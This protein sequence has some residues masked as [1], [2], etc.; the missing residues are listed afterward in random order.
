[1]KNKLILS[2]LSGVLLWAGWPTSFAFPL[3]FIAL[4][5]LYVL[6]DTIE[7]DD[8]TIKKGRAV[9]LYSFITFFTWNATTT[10]WIWNAS[11]GGA[12][13]AIIANALLMTIPVLINFHIWKYKK[14]WFKGLSFAALWLVF[15]YGHLR[16]DLSWVW[17]NLGNAFA[18]STFL[19][20]WYEYTG[21]LGGSAWI[22]IVNYL[23]YLGLQKKSFK[24]FIPA[25][26]SI[27][28]PIIFSIYL[29]LNINSISTNHD[30]AL[31]NAIIV[32]PN[33]DPYKEKFFT[34][35]NFIPFEDQ[36]LR[37]IKLSE[38]KMNPDTRWLIWPET[39]IQ[40]YRPF[41]EAHI[42]Q[43]PAIKR[44][45]LFLSDYPKVKII[46]G[47]DTWGKVNPKDAHITAPKYHKK[48]GY[49]KTYNSAIIITKD[50]SE[51]YHKSKLV[52]GVEVLPFPSILKPI[53]DL[54][55][56]EGSG[57]FGKSKEPILFGDKI[58]AAPIVCYESIYG[59]YVGEFVKKGANFIAIITNDGWWKDT[60]GYKQ[61]NLYARLRAIEHRRPVLRSANTGFSSYIDILG[62]EMIRTEWW[63]QDALSVTFESRTELTFYTKYGDWL[64]WVAL[65]AV[66]LGVVVSRK[67]KD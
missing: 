19:V 47:I 34:D 54:I 51:L 53:Q 67:T 59:N 25:I 20:Q 27:L 60:Q 8:K 30:A 16:W 5:P 23:L 41:N 33:I 12:V 50:N 44:L 46:T 1:M 63:E 52:P 36:L 4:I 57:N 58:K 48:I 42:K 22:I 10:W 64:I 38:Q 7:K 9:F 65:I 11:E 55:N 17:L 14:H 45:Q 24:S 15:E 13:M 29:F 37:L 18:N 28:L 3:L 35:E 49:Y 26:T 6:L 2:I 43:V 39:A 61:H 56:F 21:T 62:R 40:G 31:Q 66:L 32:Q